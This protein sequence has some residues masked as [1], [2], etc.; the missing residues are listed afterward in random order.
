MTYHMHRHLDSMYCIMT[1]LEI[2]NTK[3][4]CLF[5]GMLSLPALL[6]ASSLFVQCG[7]VQQTG[8]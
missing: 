4:T 8:Q 5:P 3:Y 1:S 7:T 6:V 2:S